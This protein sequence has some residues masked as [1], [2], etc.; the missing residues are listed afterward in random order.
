MLLE[1]I[2]ESEVRPDVQHL[3]A[4]SITPSDNIVKGKDQKYC[5]T[6]HLAIK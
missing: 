3:H 2:H 5:M 4:V 1:A 6:V